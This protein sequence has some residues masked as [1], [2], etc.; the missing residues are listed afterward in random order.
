MNTN[1]EYQKIVEVIA[2][3]AVHFPLIKF[4]CKNIEGKRTDVN[5]H[6]VN[7]PDSLVN[8]KDNTEDSEPD[9]NTV[10]N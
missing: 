1:D 7:R 2:R 4:S 9:T 10:L 3:Y 5:T 8:S 6:S